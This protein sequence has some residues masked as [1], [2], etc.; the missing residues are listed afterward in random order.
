MSLQKFINNALSSVNRNRR[1]KSVI[2]Q[3][4]NSDQYDKGV[5]NIH[6]IDVNNVG[7]FYCAPHHYFSE[8]KDKKLDIY[9]FKSTDEE[10]VKEWIEKIA[11]NSLIIGGGGLLNRGSFEMQMKLFEKLASGGKKTV[12]WGVGH[13]SKKTNQFRKINSYN[14]NIKNF[15]LVGVR[16]YNMD[17]NWVPCVSCLH[18]IFDKPFSEIQ[19]IGIIFHKKTLKNKSILKKLKNYPTTSNTTD[20]D[21]IISFIGKSNT[22]VTDSYHAMYW[23]MLLGKKV[24][25]VPNSSKFY[26]FKFK[27]I[28]ST[29]DNFKNDISKAESYTGVLEECRKINIEF[30]NKVFDYL[31]L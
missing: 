12:L 1:K 3:V 30:S 24:V 8:L 22:I 11:T 28:I 19:E 31:N 16:D 20:L 4:L 18:S 15:G 14:I 27:P 21:K 2:Q 26:D 9:D 10:I 29:F 6:R 7:D 25:V 5:I 13:N 23:S 17:E